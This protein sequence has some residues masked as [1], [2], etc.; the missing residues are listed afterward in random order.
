VRNVYTALWQIYSRDAVYQILSESVEVSRRYNEIKWIHFGFLFLG[1][2]VV[3]LNAVKAFRQSLCLISY[4]GSL[5][6]NSNGF[7]V[8]DILFYVEE[9]RPSGS[10]LDVLIS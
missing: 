3:L 7:E 4:G 2:D 5:W 10:Q 1:H 6:A 8:D 9:Q